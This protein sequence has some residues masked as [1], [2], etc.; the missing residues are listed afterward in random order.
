[1]APLFQL[2]NESLCSANIL[3]INNLPYILLS[4]ILIKTVL[5]LFRELESKFQYTKGITL[6]Q[7][8]MNTN[9]ETRVPKA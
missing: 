4:Q 2:E 1:M 3:V 9:R 7:S 8:K 6:E 5:V